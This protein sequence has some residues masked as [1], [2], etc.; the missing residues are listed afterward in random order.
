VVFTGLSG[1]GRFAVGAIFGAG[2]AAAVITTAVAN[3]P[4]LS[5]SAN[6]P[7]TFFSLPTE[8]SITVPALTTQVDSPTLTSQPATTGHRHVAPVHSVATAPSPAAVPLT[9]TVMPSTTPPSRT[10]STPVPPA[11]TCPWRFWW[12]C[13]Q[14]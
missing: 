7:A 14:Y 11:T 13:R 2:I 12:R 6:P 4:M 3:T 5:A 10:T 9:P 8:P 1:Q